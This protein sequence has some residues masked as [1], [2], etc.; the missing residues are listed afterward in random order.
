MSCEDTCISV[1]DDGSGPEFYREATRRAAKPHKCDECG[2]TIT[3]GQSH[4]YVSGKWEGDFTVYRTCLPCVEIRKVFCCDGFCLSMLW[5]DMAEQV[6]DGWDEMKAV[7]CLARLKTQGA[8]DKMRAK[9]AEY[10]KRRSPL[11]MY[12]AP[13][14]EKP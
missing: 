8:I 14:Q 3:V 13:N 6:F 12:A 10:Q 4:Q 7:D 11:A 1:G 9:Y 5:E 2:D